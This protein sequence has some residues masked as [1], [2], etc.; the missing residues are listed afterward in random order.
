M[1]LLQN[2]DVC[3]LWHLLCIE[4]KRDSWSINY[5]RMKQSHISSCVT[6]GYWSMTHP[7]KQ[8]P[9][10][11]LLFFA[12]KFDFIQKSSLYKN[13]N[14][15]LQVT[16]KNLS[17]KCV[18]II[19]TVTNMY[20][21]L[22]KHRVASNTDTGSGHIELILWSTAYCLTCRWDQQKSHRVLQCINVAGINIHR[23]S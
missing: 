2:S 6:P 21:C 1:V 23:I 11:L 19:I 3:L 15:C 14:S 18:E 8:R 13:P 20:V 10:L 4:Q 16:Q 7:T 9:L 12:L 22:Y 5:Q 17:Y